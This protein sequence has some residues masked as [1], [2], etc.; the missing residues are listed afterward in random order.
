MRLFNATNA[1]IDVPLSHNQR[2]TVGPFETS[3]SFMPSPD[4]L[5]V[6]V[7]A[8][9]YGDVYLIVAGPSEYQTCNS[10]S[11]ANGFVVNSVEEAM[12]LSKD[13]RIKAGLLLEE[14]A[15]SEQE[16]PEQ[17]E[18]E[19]EEEDVVGEPELE[20]EP[21]PVPVETVEEEPKGKPGR[22]KKK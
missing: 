3:G 8:F 11:G 22:K 12:D 1:S 4:F 2:L 20:S 17:E 18:P 13:A 5:S 16:E 14:E 15:K 9:D 7:T 6:I 19:Q 21:E 10:V